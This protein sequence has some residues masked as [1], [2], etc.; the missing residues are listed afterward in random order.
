MRS[1][2]A[3]LFAATLAAL[4]LTLALTIAI[5]AVLTRRQV[6]RS[7]ASAVA[8]RADD[9]AAQRQQHISYIRED[10]KL[11]G[12]VRKL[13]QPRPALVMLVPDVNRSSDGETTYQGQRQLYSYRTLPHLGLLLLRPASLRSTAWRPFLVDLL[14]AA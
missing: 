14:L 13:I 1:L 8:R 2:R 12:N 4:A 9:L 7:Q 11:A 5:G 3:R 6:D 10:K